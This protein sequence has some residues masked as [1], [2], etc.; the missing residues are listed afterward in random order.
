MR[1]VQLV[2][3]S[4]SPR[5]HEILN[6]AGIP[7]EIIPTNAEWADETLPPADRVLALAKS[8]AQD[9]A[10]KCPDRLVLGSDTMVVLDDLVLGKPRSS[11]QAVDMLLSL[12]GKEHSVM[13]GVWLTLT[14]AE[15]NA[16]K[17]DGFTDVATVKFLPFDRD[18]A[19]SYVSTGESNDKAGAYGIQGKGMRFV[20]YIHGDFYTIMGLPSGK[21]IRFIDSFLED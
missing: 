7:H 20:E 15:G 13:T 3:A 8:K 17:E 12:Q 10:S 16:V 19:L 5:R 2:L 21:L 1:D 18:E 14:D 9:V 6:L 11:E 4:A